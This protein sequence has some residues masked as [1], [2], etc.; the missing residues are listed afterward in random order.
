[1]TKASVAF[2][3]HQHQPYYPDDVSGETLMPWVRLH[4]TKDYIGMA[5]HMQEVPEFRCTIN[6]VPSLVVQIQRYV[7]GGSDR[8]LDV[9]RAPADT[10]DRTDALYLLDHFFMA[11]PGNMIDPYPRY[12]ELYHKR[13]PGRQSAEHALQAFNAQDFRDLQIWSNLTW[14]HELVFERDKELQA[15]RQKGRDW[16]EAEKAWLL[17]KQRQIIGEILPLHAQLVA[18]GQLELTT[19]PFYHPILPLLWDKRSARQ[20]M[21]QCDLPKYLDQYKEDA[22]EH[23]RMGVAQHTEVFGAKPRGMWPSEG[24]VSQEILGAIIETGIEWIATDE[25]ILSHS[26]DHFVHRTASHHIN[27]P[28]MLY[29][30][31][32]VEAD[33]KSLQ[34]IFRD[35]GL[36]DLI[37][38]EYQRNADSVWA[39]KDLLH[40]CSEIGRVCRGHSG[41]NPPLIPIILDGENCWEYY[42][43][44][45]VTFLRTLYREAAKHTQLESV[46]V[47][48]HLDRYPATDKINRLFAGSW[49]N[50]DFYIWIGHRED[51]DAW[52]ALHLAREVLIRAEKEAKHAPEVLKSARRELMI[53]QGSD[54]F[55][56]YGDDH[57]SAQDALFDQLFRRHLQNIYQLLREPVPS[58]L[59]RPIKRIEKRIIHTQ[60]RSFLRMNV[61]GKRNFYDWL[62]AGVYT[63]GSERG[64]MTKV[65]TGL[66]KHVCFGF[67]ED[68]L[69][70]RLDTL[71]PA[72][73]EFKAVD[74]LRIR[75]IEPDGTEIRIPLQDGAP[76]KIALLRD[77]TLEPPPTFQVGIGAIVELGIPLQ[78]IGVR[79]GEPLQWFVELYSNRQS[80]DRAPGEGVID[81]VVPTPDFDYR[82]WQV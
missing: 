43:D 31:W 24:S 77:G 57:S 12:R 44:G 73:E 55:W 49:I 28:E 8:H 51:R 14:I 68:T 20:A 2:F 29:R 25:E 16:T 27:R 65:T 74:E 17:E 4:G 19:T 38:F 13:A 58:H 56:W 63:A 59:Y 30:P 47:Q 76:G 64:T 3:W 1:M 71:G 81:T 33:G 75:F 9:S 53:A 42:R 50:H 70:V 32:R 6:L 48:D 23:L 82:M 18:G 79:H 26:T 61:D 46:R 22:R 80:I 67:N 52:D 40:K 78:T 37:G 10:L 34:I 36:S 11:N 15:F 45:G 35:H 69:F 21:T 72:S 41:N 54:W 62:M 66:I 5:L 60:P 7:A 39:A